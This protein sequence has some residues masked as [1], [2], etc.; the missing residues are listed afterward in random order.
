MGFKQPFGFLGELLGDG[1]YS[2]LRD[3][4][5]AELEKAFDIASPITAPDLERATTTLP[6]GPAQPISGSKAAS[7]S[8]FVK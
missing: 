6:G 7:P 3:Q 2:H 4:L 5:K 1:E 8:E